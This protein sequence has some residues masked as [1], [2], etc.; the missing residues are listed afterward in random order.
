MLPPPL[1]IACNCGSERQP[2][3]RVSAQEIPSVI[4]EQPRYRLL[5]P[6]ACCCNASRGRRATPVAAALSRCGPRL[7]AP[8]SP[9]PPPLQSVVKS[10]EWRR[11]ALPTPPHHVRGWVVALAFVLESLVSSRQT[12]RRMRFMLIGDGLAGKTRVAA[13]LLNAQGD[14]HPDVAITNCTM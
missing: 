6:S 4:W 14:N 1:Y 5:C 2:L 9:L 7:P 13:A 8:A 11:T 10:E 3:V 12:V